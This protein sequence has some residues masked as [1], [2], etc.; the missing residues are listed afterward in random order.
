MSNYGGLLKEQ[1]RLEE[2]GVLFKED[3]DATREVWGH[4]SALRR[5]LRHL[6]LILHH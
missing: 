6:R 2:A 1:G 3:L 4:M 5:I